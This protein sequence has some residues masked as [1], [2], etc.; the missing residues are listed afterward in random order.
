MPIQLKRNDTSYFSG[1]NYVPKD[2]EVCIEEVSS[3]VFK[4]KFG[5]KYQTPWNSLYY[6]LVSTVGD[7]SLSGI[8]NFNSGILRNAVISSYGENVQTLNIVNSGLN[9]NLASGNVFKISLSSN[10]TGINIQSSYPSG[11]LHP[12]TIILD[13]IA[14]GI[15][16]T[17]PTN[18][19]WNGGS[20]SV[21]TLGSGI[22]RSAVISLATTDGGSTYFGFLGGN[23]FGV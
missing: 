13:Y 6:P 20:G 21:P 3:G 14:S 9:I 18:V 17:W 12:F 19:Y 4:L 15:S 22:G 7:N 2:G 10:I 11:T 5:N 16:V 23:N 1:Q 8:Q